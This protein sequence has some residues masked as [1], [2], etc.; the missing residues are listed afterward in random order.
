MQKP[1]AAI[2]CFSLLTACAMW[3]P[4]W[5]PEPYEGAPLFA[6]NCAAC[7]GAGGQ[8]DGPLAGDFDVRPPDLTQ[9]A[10]RNG[11]KF[12]MAQVLSQIDGYT[13]M[14]GRDQVM[15]EYGA[16]LEGDTVPVELGAEEFSP[17]PRP[18]AA[19]VAYLQ[20]IQKTG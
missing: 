3:A 19:I 12:P 4:D 20:D 13:R 6:E 1:V 16:L 9:I 7:H 5:M 17:V 11:G 14:Q 18:L 15:P 10:A 2:T 8:G